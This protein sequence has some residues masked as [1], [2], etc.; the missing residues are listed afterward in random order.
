MHA[1]NLFAPAH[2][3]TADYNAAVKAPGPQQ[4]G[5][6]HIR[7]VGCSHQ[8]DAFVR[9]EPV[10]LNQQLVQSLLA[11]IVA[12]AQASA[13]VTAYCVDFVDEDDAGGILLALLEQVAHAA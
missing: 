10:H 13:T 2:I 3:R 8:D 11:L 6:E 12:A 5:I 9:L 1:E 4:C 7:T